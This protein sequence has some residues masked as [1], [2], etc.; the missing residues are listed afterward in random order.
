MD[1]L[2]LGCGKRFHPSWV[3][4]NFNSTGEGVIA[5]DLSKG[6]PFPD[7]SFDVVYHSHL[8]EH[9]S[10]AA[11]KTFLQECYRVLRP[12]GILRVVVPDLEQIARTY[13]IALEKASNGSQ[14]W[15]DNYQWILLEMYDQVARDYSGGEMVKYLARETI[16]NEEFVFQRCGREAKQ[17]RESRSYQPKLTKSW[18]K[19][20]KN[21][22][23][24]Q[25]I[26]PRFVT[27]A[28]QAFKIGSFRQSGEIHQWMY[29]RYSL[30][31]LL[32]QCGGEKIIQRTAMESYVSH[33]QSFNL[34][35]EADGSVTKPDSLFMEAIKASP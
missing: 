8:L 32:K 25:D 4:I 20:L 3:N 9:F 31:C 26:L 33:W 10:Q 13:L 12:Q 23:A 29:D 28:Y 19:P 2:N 14:L 6:I 17:I 1:C 35:T 22:A 11:G 27:Q 16:P 18:L 7:A 34:D 24:R 21:L 15:A 5:H 30:S